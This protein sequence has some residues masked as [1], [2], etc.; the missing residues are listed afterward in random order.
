[1]IER[2][3]SCTCTC[4]PSTPC[5][6]ARRGCRTCSPRPRAQGDARAGDDR[7]RQRLRCL[8]LLQA[9]HAPPGS[10]RSSAWRATTPGHEPVRPAPGSRWGGGGE[11]D[12]SG[13]GAYTHMTLLA[14]TTE[15][16]H[17]LFRLSSLAS[18]E[19][20]YCKPRARPR[21]AA[22]VRQGPDRAPPAARPARSTAG[23]GWATTTGR[24]RRRP[25]TT[26][27][28]SAG[29]LLLRADGPRARDRAPGP[30]RP[31][32]ARRA[33]STSRC[34]RPTTCTTPSPTTPRRTRSCCACRPA[35]PWPTRTGSGSTPATS[36]SRPPPEMRQVWRELPEACD[37]T[38]LIA[39][40]CDV[41]FAEGADLM[42]RFPVPEGETEESWLVKEVERGLEL[43]FPGGVP[44][45][46]R[47]QARRTRSASSPRWASPAT[48]SSS[49]TSCR[50]R[51]G[52]RHPGRSR[53]RVGGRL[54]DRLRAAASPSST[55]S[56][57]GC[58]SSGSSTPSASRCP[59]STST[60]TSVGAAT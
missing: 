5:S 19:G 20:Y 41:A 36:T 12:V 38:L 47:E 16:M 2:T 35:R 50:L 26:A 40:R 42:P 54:A 28:S 60:S 48:S 10:S 24:G 33:S 17:N 4:T 30:R 52:E 6:T 8:R 56:S 7:P 32:P 58:S 13:G 15:G 21:A 46:H 23:C 9:G 31:A 22:D 44:D 27:T 37:N 25:P 18:L 53:P 55:R 57:T 14:E 43:R 29:Q 45:A 51:Q 49:P 39:E 1:M 59:T 3:R 34:S 11:D